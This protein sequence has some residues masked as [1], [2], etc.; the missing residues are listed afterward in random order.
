MDLGVLMD[1]GGVSGLRGAVG[2]TGGSPWGCSPQAL[3]RVLPGLKGAEVQ[4]ALQPPQ[5]H[6]L[7][8]G[9][10]PT[11]PPQVAPRLRHQQAQH[12]LVLQ[13]GGPRGGGGG[14][15]MNT[16]GVTEGGGGPAGGPHVVPPPTSSSL[17]FGKK[18]LRRR[19]RHGSSGGGNNVSP[20][21][22]KERIPKC[23]SA[24]HPKEPDP[25]GCAPQPA[26]PPRAPQALPLATAPGGASLRRSTSSAHCRRRRNGC[27]RGFSCTSGGAP[28]CRGGR[29]PQI[30]GVPAPKYP[31][32]PPLPQ[33]PG[34]RN[35]KPQTP[36]PPQHQTW[37][38]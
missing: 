25:M 21:R 29:H 16:E 36:K 38:F 28:R 1:L 26:P 19:C 7:L 15:V 12:R 13:L 11:T 17:C 33:N 24:P 6:S 14:G 37:A 18:T 27:C 10:R 35:P 9:Q 4:T 20:R 2:G 30:L 31:P 5:L 3:G 23:T 32:I 34:S 8:G 22:P